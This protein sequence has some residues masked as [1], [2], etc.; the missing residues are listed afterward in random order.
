[1]KRAEQL[2]RAY[3]A[4]CYFAG[5][6][7]ARIGQRAP[8]LDALLGSWRAAEGV[9]I[10]AGNPF[11]RRMPAGWN[12]QRHA[13]LRQ[14]LRGL[15][16]VEGQGGAKRWWEAHCFIGISATRGRRLAR[17]FRQNAVVALRRRGR[18]RL[19]WVF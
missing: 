1:M 12:A 7:A 8:G 9:F 19:I 6:H 10:A 18:A 5:A 13:A 15:H 2:L 14:R 4:S 16:Y 11:S 17:L 3:R